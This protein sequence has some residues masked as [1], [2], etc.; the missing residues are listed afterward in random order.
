VENQRLQHLE[1][2]RD[3][4]RE[5]MGEFKRQIRRGRE[6]FTERGEK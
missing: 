2:E 1:T 4:L 3:E 6:G 5:S